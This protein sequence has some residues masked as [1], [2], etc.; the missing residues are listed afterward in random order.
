[1]HWIRRRI[2][3]VGLTALL[4]T[5]A[6]V[7]ASSQVALARQGYREAAPSRFN[8]EYIFATT[9]DVNDMQGVPAGLKLTLFPVTIVL[10]TVF[11]PF[12]VIAGF[13]S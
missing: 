5:G 4:A 10:D 1:M 12:A 13:V 6:S 11:L 8:D 9:R 7:M 2:V 3:I